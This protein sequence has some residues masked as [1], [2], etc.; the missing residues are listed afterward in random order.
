[1]DCACSKNTSAQTGPATYVVTAAN[2]QKST[3]KTE[4]EAIAAAQRQGG[5]Y[6]AQ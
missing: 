4:V 3:Y 5:T 1:M 2:G 6:Q